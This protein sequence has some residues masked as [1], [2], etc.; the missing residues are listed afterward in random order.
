MNT[1]NSYR[2]ITELDAGRH[3]RNV[4]YRRTDP[5]E[6]WQE[7]AARDTQAVAG[8]SAAM[9]TLVYSKGPRASIDNLARVLYQAVYRKY[10]LFIDESDFWADQSG[11]VSRPFMAFLQRQY[12]LAHAACS[13]VCMWDERRQEMVCVRSLDWA[14]AD[15]LA[16]CTRI[17]KFLDD[18]SSGPVFQ[19]AGVAGMVGILTGMKDG[20]SL[21]INYAP[22]HFAAR[23][24]PD[25]LFA[26]RNLLQDE[27]VQTYGEA[28]HR[29]ERWKVAAPCFITIC[30]RER[31]EACVVA[32]GARKNHVRELNES[33]FIIQTNHVDTGK[34]PFSR[35]KKNFYYTEEPPA[36]EGGWYGSNLM[37]NSK[38]RRRRIERHVQTIPPD[39][40][41][42]DEEILKIY[43]VPPVLNHE[44]AQW[45]VM[46]PKSRAMKVFTCTSKP[47]CPGT[48]SGGTGFRKN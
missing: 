17:F 14:G 30:G 36:Q 5:A 46:R 19:A 45:V 11:C 48:G 24:N 16:A 4:F 20:F 37:R 34:A 22:W 8:L 1:D 12:T 7:V 32:C 43:L 9:Q 6:I 44:T 27:A 33:G 10:G 47:D 42:L 35:R 15:Q 3:G 39:T 2:V 29:V 13:A 31:G 41:C 26:I 23:F 38:E 18:A 25:P 21:C 40:D 28:K